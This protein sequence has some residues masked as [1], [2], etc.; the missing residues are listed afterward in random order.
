MKETRILFK[1][2]ENAFYNKYPEGYLE[3]TG[4]K[5]YVKFNKSSK[6]YTYKG[7]LV[8][9]AEKLNLEV[10]STDMNRA[11][12]LNIEDRS[13]YLDF[14]GNRGKIEIAK[15]KGGKVYFYLEADKGW[16]IYQNTKGLF[17]KVY[18]KNYYL[19]DI[20][21]PEEEAKEILNK[22]NED[23]KKIEEE[24]EIE[25]SLR[26]NFEIVD[27]VLFL[28]DRKADKETALMVIDDIIGNKD[29]SSEFLTEILSHI[30]DNEAKEVKV[31]DNRIKLISKY[32]II[33]EADA[34]Y[35]NNFPILTVYNVKVYGDDGNYDF[36]L[37][38]ELNANEWEELKGELNNTE[39]IAFISI[40][41][42]FA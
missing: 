2:L 23:N 16:K 14:E 10:A 39:D 41:I 36:Y 8:E 32:G 38:L 29:Y 12:L 11:E 20:E 22:Q 13:L 6:L 34:E 4:N 37:E 26:N 40:S 25:V 1:D 27:D 5:M 3:R 30:E 17:I 21:V 33:I 24:Q 31:N 35:N 19:N 28:N 7:K 9:I 15:I 42:F 18:G